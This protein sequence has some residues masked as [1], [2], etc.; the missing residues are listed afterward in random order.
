MAARA[1]RII[2]LQP[3]RPL[4]N[5]PTCSSVQSG[6]LKKVDSI[7]DSTQPPPSGAHHAQVVRRCHLRPFNYAA[8][9]RSSPSETATSTKTPPHAQ[10]S[11]RHN[12]R[13]S[14]KTAA[15]I[16]I[17]SPLLHRWP[18]PAARTRPGAG[19][20]PLSSITS[21]QQCCE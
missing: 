20:H 15:N 10:C 9:R 19:R 7:L 8:L 12:T 21:Q 11:V 2:G 16:Q 18:T 1:M 13:S 4:T 5:T 14:C 6:L 3:P 17:S